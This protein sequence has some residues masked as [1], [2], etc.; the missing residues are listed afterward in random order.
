MG[1]YTS[2][3]LCAFASPA[4]NHPGIGITRANGDTNESM[5]DIRP[6]KTLMQKRGETGI[7]DSY[8][9]C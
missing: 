4:L 3:Q 8:S 7:N 2:L 9:R 5:C 6:K 1:N